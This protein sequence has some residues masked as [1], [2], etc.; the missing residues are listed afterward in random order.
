MARD[1]R[2]IFTDPQSSG[3][4]I[5]DQIRR[6]LGHVMA[7]QRKSRSTW[8]LSDERELSATEVIREV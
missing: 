5:N 8:A 3:L 2:N 7:P 6:E 1:H 4:A